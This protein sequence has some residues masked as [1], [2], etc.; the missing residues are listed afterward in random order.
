MIVGPAESGTAAW[1]DG[2]SGGDPDTDAVVIL[3][4]D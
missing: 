4:Y 2:G 1:I 3:G